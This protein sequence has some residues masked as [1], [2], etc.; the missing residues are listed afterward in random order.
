MRS[1]RGVRI[2]AAVAAL[3]LLLAGC[4]GFEIRF[5][6]E[7]G[8]S[9]SSSGSASK[10]APP[11]QKD[12]PPAQGGQRSTPPAA[13]AQP[14]PAVANN[15]RV[16]LN[17][18]DYAGDIVIRANNTTIAGRGV[19]ATRIVGDVTIVGNNVILRDLTIVGNVQIRGNGADLRE[20]RIQGRVTASG[21][22]GLW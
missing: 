20:T 15:A 14:F 5:V 19:G 7:G 22:G 16:L 6:P 13:K 12:A 11:A 8:R 18:G 17:P 1:T 10:E 2:V 9:G 21:K 4:A 3:V